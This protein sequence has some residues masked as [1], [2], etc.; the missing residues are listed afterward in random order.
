MR[1]IESDNQNQLL[2][3]KEKIMVELAWQTEYH[4][5]LKNHATSEIRKITGRYGTLP[6]VRRYLSRIRV[7][8]M[9][10][11]E[12]SLFNTHYV[13][14]ELF[15]TD[16]Y[17][18]I[19]TAYRRHRDSIPELKTKIHTLVYGNPRQFHEVFTCPE[20][21]FLI[22]D[23]W[24]Q[25]SIVTDSSYDALTL[26]AEKRHVNSIGFFN[27][28][29]VLTL[30]KGRILSGEQTGLLGKPVKKVAFLNPKDNTLYT[31]EIETLWCDLL[32]NN[33]ETNINETFILSS[34]NHA[35]GRRLDEEF[36]YSR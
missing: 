25:I 14:P 8:R 29:G 2:L 5:A 9:D 15:T 30:R 31:G 13:F 36:K 19:V 24:G 1:V 7:E 17:D 4:L 20:K 16:E 12:G 26:P 32:Y 18:F 28:D 11:G 33:R 27:D 10:A 21:F 6:K 23:S 35:S 34:I 22:T 3:I